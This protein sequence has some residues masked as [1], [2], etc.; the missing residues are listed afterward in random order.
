[1]IVSVDDH[2]KPG[3]QQSNQ[4]FSWVHCPDLVSL[5]TLVVVMYSCVPWEVADGKMSEHF[6]IT[7]GG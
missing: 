4:F 6:K 2:S 1:M 7:F 5:R 3:P